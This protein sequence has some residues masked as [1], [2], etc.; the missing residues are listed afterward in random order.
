MKKMKLWHLLTILMLFLINFVYLLVSANRTFAVLILVF[1]D[2]FT[3]LL[4]NSKKNILMLCYLICFFVFLLGKPIAVNLFGFSRYSRVQLSSEATNYIYICLIISILSLLLGFLFCSF[5]KK[6]KN[7]NKNADLLNYSM[8]PTIKKITRILTIVILLLVIVENIFKTLF[9]LKVGYTLSYSLESAYT[10]PYGLHAVIEVAPVVFCLFLATMP[11]KKEAKIPILL[12]I[13]SNF[14][15]A[16]GGQ[17]F[18]IISS[19]LFIFVYLIFRND[20]E[21][22]KI[23]IS[24]KFVVL[25]ILVIPLVVYFLQQMIYWRDNSV[26]NM[27][28][29]VYVSFLY[30]VGSSSDLI[31]M[32][33]QYG[34]RCLDSDVLYSFGNVWRSLNGN[35]IAKLINGGIKYKN[36]TIDYAIEG[37]SL[38]SRLTYYF[39]P[40]KYLNGYGLGGCYIAELLHDFSIVGVIV[41]NFIIGFLIGAFKRIEKNKTFRNFIGLFMI[42]SLFRIPRD[43]FDYFIVTFLGIKNIACFVFLILFSNIVYKYNSSLKG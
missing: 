3:L 13:F 20:D 40:E 31:G 19:M 38:S 30:G 1:I 18:G 5:I 41:G 9:M 4:F 43:S 2:V 16:I 14:I 23:W 25:I 17:R 29:G 7:H 11:T 15:L 12:Y 27:E 34:G 10:L 42:I 6:N 37:H 22:K 28:Q 24:K 33:Y 32:T 36:Q 39:Y 21:S 8:I 26:N 35:I